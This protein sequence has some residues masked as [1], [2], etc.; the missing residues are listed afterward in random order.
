VQS[1]LAI[2]CI[3]MLLYAAYHLPK[4]EFRLVGP[5]I[6]RA[7]QEENKLLIGF[8]FFCKTLATFLDLNMHGIPLD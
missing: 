3:L 5:I 2:C 4:F 8:G 6:Y 7:I 1:V